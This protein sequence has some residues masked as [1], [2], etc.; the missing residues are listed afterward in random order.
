MSERLETLRSID[1]ALGEVVGDMSALYETLELVGGANDERKLVVSQLR[2]F[3]LRL[4]EIQLQIKDS[5]ENAG[6]EGPD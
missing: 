1:A 4:Q 5:P 3:V 2:V 6:Q